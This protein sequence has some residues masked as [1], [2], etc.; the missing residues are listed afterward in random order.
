MSLF[1]AAIHTLHNSHRQRRDLICK[2]ARILGSG[3]ALM[4]AQGKCILLCTRHFK[5]ARHVFCR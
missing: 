4:A 5:L 2:L 1:G 3:R